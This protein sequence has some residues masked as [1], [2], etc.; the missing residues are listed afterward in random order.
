LIFKSDHKNQLFKRAILI[1]TNKNIV[2]GYESKRIFENESGLGNYGRNLINILTTYYPQ[3]KYKLFA[4]KITNLYTPPESVEVITPQTGFW[5]YFS[6]YWRL[7][8]S[9]LQIYKS[10][11][12]I[13]H[14][15]SHVLP[16]RIKKTGIPAVLTIHDLIFLRFPE[17]FKKVDR[18]MYE[19]ITRN[20]CNR[21]DKIIAISAQT[22][23]DLIHYFNIEPAKIEVVY[24]TL[25]NLF[26]ERVSSESKSIIRTKFNLPEKFLLSVGTIEQRK[27]QLAILKG[28]KA[29]N[30]KMP[31][32]LVGKPSKYLEEINKYIS[33]A[34]LQDQVILL[35]E[36][37]DEE[38]EGIYQMAEIMI[39]PSFFEGFGL[40]VIEAQ[41]SQCPV[42]TSNTSSLPEA[43][44]EGAIYIDPNNVTE[45]GQAIQ[46]LLQ[47]EDLR[48]DL[49]AKGLKNIER[50]SEE[51]VAKNLMDVYS[52]ML[53]TKK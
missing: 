25:N 35:H 28:L 52:S 11:A 12:D 7:H 42:I 6:S 15:L 36:T 21:A 39:Y 44:G 53:N 34:S 27:N 33:V 24:Q 3:N 30:I 16:S 31:I 22:K 48:K 47:N 51:S 38:L 32:V 43:G 5:R 10:G 14:G 1:K 37:T 20:S 45:I 9:H 2:I 8:R 13:F 49:I 17:F 26:L 50:F 18:E 19:Y 41:A 40:P 29:E 4:P 23:N 46:R